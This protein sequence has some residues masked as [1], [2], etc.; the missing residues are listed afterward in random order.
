MATLDY[1]L[2]VEE[3]AGRG[4]DLPAEETHL[5]MLNDLKDELDELRT[6][7]NEVEEQLIQHFGLGSDLFDQAGPV[8]T[9]AEVLAENNKLT[10]GTDVDDPRPV[11]LDLAPTQQPTAGRIVRFVDNNGDAM[12]MIVSKVHGFEGVISG[13]VFPFNAASRR[14]TSIAHDAEGGND[15]WRWPDEA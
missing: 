13:H 3:M 4:P 11:E 1:Q 2:L 10:D 9:L 5:T 12:P 7:K 8:E 15:T 6:F 14:V